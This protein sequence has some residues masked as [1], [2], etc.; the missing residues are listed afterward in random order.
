M[1]RPPLVLALA[2]RFEP[3]DSHAGHL[4]RRRRHGGLAHCP[5]AS[6][7]RRDDGARLLLCDWRNPLRGSSIGCGRA[8]LAAPVYPLVLCCERADPR[9]APDN[10]GRLARHASREDGMTALKRLLPSHDIDALLGDIAEERPRRSRFWYW[11]QLLAI[12]VVASWRDIR[13]HPLVALRA[14]VTGFAT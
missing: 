10:R 3:R 9:V 1:V 11:S 12:V 2:V 13:N 8:G 6:R 4:D 7:T 14:I 5:A